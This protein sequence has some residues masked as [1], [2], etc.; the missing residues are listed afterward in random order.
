VMVGTWAYFGPTI[1]ETSLKREEKPVIR[2][3]RGTDGVV[4]VNRSRASS[5]FDAYIF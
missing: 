4:T 5:S 1:R 2:F 3:V